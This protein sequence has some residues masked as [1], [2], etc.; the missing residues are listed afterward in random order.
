MYLFLKKTTKEKRTRYYKIH[1]FK[2]LL[3]DFILSREYGNI[4]N[5]GP[6]R[7]IE[8]VKSSF[9]Q[10]AKEALALCGTKERKG[11]VVCLGDRYKHQASMCA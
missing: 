1:V 3:G 6:T 9:A 10:A 4:S 11:Y 8:E 2:N 5:K 7:I